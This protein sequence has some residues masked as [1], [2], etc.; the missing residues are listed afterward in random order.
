MRFKF[1]WDRG[2]KREH[3][4]LGIAELFETVGLLYI[5]L[6]CLTLIVISL[7]SLDGTAA[8]VADVVLA[9]NLAFFLALRP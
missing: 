8:P 5:G 2:E 4:A 6:L 9:P 1:E 7:S 3:D